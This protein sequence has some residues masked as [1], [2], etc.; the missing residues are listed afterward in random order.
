[1][2]LI[3]GQGGTGATAPDP[4]R[5]VFTNPVISDPRGTDHGDPFVLRHLNSYFLYHTTD[6]GDAGISV[7][8]SA[9]LVH[10]HFEGFALEPAQGNH[11]AQTDLWAPEVMA[12]RGLFYMYVSATR[13][14]PDGHGFEAL[15]RQGLARSAAPTGPFVLDDAPLVRD[16]WSIDGHPF[17]DEDGKLW[18]FYNT[19]TPATR[20]D[21]YRGSGTVVD[22]LLKPDRLEGSPT[23]VAFP[24]E[25]WEG[26]AAGDEFWNEAS[27]V[28]KR[29][30]RYYHLYSGGSYRDA[31]YGVGITAADRPRGPWRKDPLN[32]VF[33]SGRRIRGP[34]HHSVILAPDGVTFYAVYHAYDGE[35]PG[36]KIHLDP[37]HWAGDRP[38]IG[39]D[40]VAGR[41]TEEAQP[42]PPRP[43]F[44][45]AV[46]WWQA[47]IWAWGSALEIDGH[48]VVLPASAQALR[49]RVN[50]GRHG[51]RVWV[52]GRLH[53]QEPGD[54]A[55][56]FAADGELMLASLTSSLTDEAIRWLAPGERHAWSWGGDGPVE[57]VLAVLGSCR[58]TAG[59]VETTATSP[60]DRF[61]LVRLHA[62][63]GTAEIIVTG[64][65]TGAQVTDLFVAAR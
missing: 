15:R 55:P 14:G 65:D 16:V 20:F 49:V 35:Q 51:L 27:W 10:W 30:G 50:Q 46:P 42:L 64:R 24:S 5:E 18:L 47:D 37:L 22:R 4:A 32:P 41:P 23:P 36:R 8:R 17:Q 31:T 1:M 57:V 9:D 54:H 3:H 60:Q 48:Q 39:T 21:G 29:R 52:D 7:Y 61:A 43:V 13:L 34:G 6:D 2:E 33:R 25:R 40:A 26:N 59:K 44:D 63:G 28:L 19:R 45:P 38:I 58:L 53:Y 56:R 11:W 12:W 62:P